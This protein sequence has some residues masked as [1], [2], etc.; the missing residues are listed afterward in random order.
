MKQ[1]IPL[2]L[3]ERKQVG[4]LYHYTSILSL[5]K[6]LDS[7]ILGDESLGKHARVSLTR[8]KNFHKRT[9]IVPTECKIYIDGEKLSDNYKITPY[10]WNASHFSGGKATKNGII[11]DQMEEEVQGYVKG[12][13]DY[14][15]KIEIFELELDP[16]PFDDDFQE[17][18]CGILKMDK[19]DISSQDII[20][21]IKSHV[22]DVTVV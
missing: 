17:V 12:V 20:D 19:E 11:E 1:I 22:D 7:N 8:D 2:P 18:A 4:T 5:L 15:Q 13:I 10:Q 14:I 9:K 21:F 16:L 3:Y 6:I